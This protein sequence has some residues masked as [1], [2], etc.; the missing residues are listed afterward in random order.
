MAKKRAAVVRKL[1]ED[2]DEK[3]PVKRTRKNSMDM[4]KDEK[5]AALLI[6]LLFLAA[7][8]FLLIQ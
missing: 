6:V 5:Y 4:T 1:P 2:M 8:Y 7:M 3:T